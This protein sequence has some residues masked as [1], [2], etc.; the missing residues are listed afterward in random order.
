M[1]VSVTRIH[2]FEYT[3]PV[4]IFFSYF[5]TEKVAL[6]FIYL[7]WLSSLLLH[8]FSF[9]YF[10][11]N[12]HATFVNLAYFNPHKFIVYMLKVSQNDEW[13][14]CKIRMRSRILLT[15]Y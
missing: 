1:L 12:M 13:F 2:F 3:R 15:R 5:E 11:C 4:G 8:F 10:F 9:V 14:C 7:T 6:I